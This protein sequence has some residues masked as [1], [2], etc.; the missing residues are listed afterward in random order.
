VSTHYTFRRSTGLFVRL[1]VPKALRGRLKQR[2]I[3]RK[4]PAGLP[5]KEARQLAL[6]LQLRL[7]DLFAQMSRTPSLAPDVSALVDQWLSEALQEDAAMRRAHPGREPLQIHGDLRAEY[8]EALAEGRLSAIRGEAEEIAR[9]VGLPTSGPEF[10]KLSQGLLRAM[11]TY[12]DEAVRRDEGD[13]QWP[14][15]SPSVP[16]APAQA[17][18]KATPDG[19]V[20]SQ[21]AQKF[22][23]ENKTTTWSTPKTA[24]SYRRS[25]QDLVEALGDVAVT[26]LD[27]KSASSWGTWLSA[28]LA[29]GVA[30]VTVQN[31]MNHCRTFG[32]WLVKK[33]H[34][35]TNLLA[36][37]IRLKATKRADEE[38][39]AFNEKQLAV[40]LPFVLRQTGWR[41]WVPL[42]CLHAGLR[43]AEAAQLEGPDIREI[44]GVPCIDVTDSN[45]RRL[46]NVQSRRYVPVHPF[47][48]SRNC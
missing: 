31:K 48:L 7:Q 18:E 40:L 28:Q 16:A 35:G 9:K 34:L 36:A 37:P 27:R 19:P 42:L 11:L 13:W 1:I 45:G 12:L 38:R 32:H 8:A 41:K 30:K 2:E 23:E 15:T 4:V 22:I 10:D 47:L 21:L 44:D 25:L 20:L 3:R 43:V 29:Q 26:S 6:R 39:A 24:L 46:K 14:L 5:K 33:G 17:T